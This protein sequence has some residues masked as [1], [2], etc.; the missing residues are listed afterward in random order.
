MKS[1]LFSVSSLLIIG[2]FC[3]FIFSINSDDALNIK[4]KGIETK[5]ILKEGISPSEFALMTIE[6]NNSPVKV[7]QFEIVLAR[8]TRAIFPGSQTVSGNQF[9]LE[10]L[11]DVAK[12]GDRIVIEILKFS[13]EENMDNKS[14]FVVI[15]VK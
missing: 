11:S 6:R 12:A 7:Q 2:L 8:G 13:G 5:N 14:S 3:S 1:Y 9:D 15:Q 10:D 4:V